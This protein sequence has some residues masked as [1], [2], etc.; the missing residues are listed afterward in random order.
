MNIYIQLKNGFTVVTFNIQSVMKTNSY[1]IKILLQ[2]K[3]QIIKYIKIS[4]VNLKY[5][6][7]ISI[8][9]NQFIII[10]NY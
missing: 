4:K 9:I 7:F 1:K 5:T 2:F 10:I 8:K 3:I 6:I